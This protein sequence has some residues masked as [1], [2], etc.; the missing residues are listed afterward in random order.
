MRGSYL[1]H[2]KTRKERGIRQRVVDSFFSSEKVKMAD[3]MTNTSDITYCMIHN[4]VFAGYSRAFQ[5]ILAFNVNALR[6]GWG[7]QAVVKKIKPPNIITQIS[8]P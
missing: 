3:Q 8:V 7:V 6:R 2:I 5:R 1:K 4:T